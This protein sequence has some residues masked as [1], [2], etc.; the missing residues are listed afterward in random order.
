MVTEGSISDLLGLLLLFLI[1]GAD[2]ALLYFLGDDLSPS[3]P[4]KGR[5]GD[6]GRDRR[7]FNT[8]RDE[9]VRCGVL[10]VGGERAESDG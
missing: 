6:G 2:V 1:G 9:L 5:K 8:E 3:S 7:C 10:G 4:S